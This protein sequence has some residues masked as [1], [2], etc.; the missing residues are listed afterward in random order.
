MVVDC[1]QMEVD[2]A[3]GKVINDGHDLKNVGIWNIGNDDSFSN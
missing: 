2:K 1:L 3:V